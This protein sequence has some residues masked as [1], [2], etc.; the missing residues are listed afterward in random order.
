MALLE[1]RALT[2]QFPG[3]RALDGVDFDLQ[4]GEAHVLFGENGA[5]KS[6]LISILAGAVKPTSGKVLLNGHAVQF[7]SVREARESG[8]SA[9]FQEF[10]LAPQLT[11]A[12]NLML[13]SEPR[14]GPFINY[15]A[16]R[17]QARRML[18]KLGFD[19]EPTRRVSTLTRAQQQMVEIAKGLRSHAQV[20]ILDEPTASLTAHET[21]Q[22]FAF[23]KR[24]KAKGVGVIYISHRIQEIDQI[25]DRVTVLRD[26]GKVATLTTPLVSQERLIELMTGRAIGQVYPQIAF[27]PQE[28]VL[29]ISALSTASGVR[30]ASLY[31]RAGEVVGIAGLVG[32]GKSELMRAA[33]G[34][35][36]VIDGS[37]RLLGQAATHASPRRMLRAGFFYLPPDRSAEGLAPNFSAID[38]IYLLASAL[39]PRHPLQLINRRHKRQITQD[40]ARRVELAGPHHTRATMLL[41]GGNQQKVLF[42]RGLTRN[43]ALYVF[44]EPT[45]GVDVGTRTALYQLIRELC[46]AGAAIVIVSSD[47]PE[48]L[49]LSHRLYVMRRGEIAGELAAGS[50]CES[51]VLSL[52][53]HHRQAAPQTPADSLITTSGRVS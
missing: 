7:R 8:V 5:G 19:L 17:R 3:I 15:P 43:A 20:L 27:S 14:Y 52:F 39:H 40:A 29:E 45:V 47:L 26:G 36:R 23:I 18:D 12:Q 42:A 11:V 38:N 16:Q 30:N 34:L 32:S 10:S 37:V 50:I 25:A 13:G 6:T 53:F 2:K 24:L 44:D 49:H 21:A 31:V 33:F 46:E 41:S 48:V 22:L 4:A 1:T 28:V 35:E 9:V 51:T